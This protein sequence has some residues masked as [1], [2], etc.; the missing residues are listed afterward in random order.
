V[1]LS[2]EELLMYARLEQLEQEKLDYDLRMYEQ[3]QRLRVDLIQSKLDY[4]GK[5]KVDR[6]TVQLMLKASESNN[7]AEL[8]E[9]KLS[10]LENTKRKTKREVSE[11]LRIA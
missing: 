6:D 1:A 8:E 7:H 2:M 11:Q 5:S 10:L 4:D 9:M 3:K